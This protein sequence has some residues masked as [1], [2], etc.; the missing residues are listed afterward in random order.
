MRRGS[1]ILLLAASGLAACAVGPDFHPPP[2]PA[3][4]D[5]TATPVPARFDA[6][7]QQQ[8]LVRGQDIPGAWWQLYRSPAL[9]RL[10]RR[11]LAAN[12]TI[13][14][15]QASLRQAREAV[16][17]QEGAY[18]PN[19]S[20]SFSPSYNKTATGSVS[21]ASASGNPYYSL[22]TAQL[23]VSFVPDVFGGTRRAVESAVAQAEAQRF[24]LEATYLTLIANLVNAAV[25][26]AGL[27]EQIEVTNRVIAFGEDALRLLR[28]QRDLGQI[29]GLDVLT[30]ET[31]VAQARATLPPLQKQLE[32][33][34]D[35]I[36]ALL[37][38]RP[39]QSPTETFTLTDLHVPT[40]LPLSLPSL[41]VAQR[42]DV[43][44]AEENARSANAQIGVAIAN[45]IPAVNLT[46]AIGSSPANLA[47]LFGPG[48][49][50]FTVAGSIAQPI[51]EGGTLLHRQRGAEAAAA[52]AD[53]QYRATV[54]AAFQNVADALH[55]LDADTRTVA[56]TQDAASTA[57]AALEVVRTQLRLGQVSYL[58]LL[59]S[60]QA[61]LQ[62]S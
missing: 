41:L 29:A 53:A 61:L 60:E 21:A 32:Q 58:A 26:E 37:G 7:G 57:A 15:A 13:E 38:R 6:A 18:F 12:P 28:K 48:Q 43:R 50:F 11:A 2:A 54:L 35:Q 55:A 31:T 49:G 59:T 51:F 52:Q 17:A 10:I 40:E 44:Q 30:Q 47:N 9:D 14:A 46:A 16:Y 8:T 62:A 39:D 36:A 24:Q 22:N 3:G 27:R 25:Q 23:S 33:N 19:V 1:A 20:A 56:A 5:Y 4:A 45:R 42:P 34:R